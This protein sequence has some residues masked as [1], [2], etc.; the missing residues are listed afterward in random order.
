[1]AMSEREIDPQDLDLPVPF[2]AR[3][4][5]SH[6]RAALVVVLVYIGVVSFAALFLFLLQYAQGYSDMRTMHA[7]VIFAV[8]M[9]FPF[10]WALRNTFRRPRLPTYQRRLPAR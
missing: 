6:Q 10:G 2:T 3:F 4:V 9:A 8:V 7:S 1:M 5:V